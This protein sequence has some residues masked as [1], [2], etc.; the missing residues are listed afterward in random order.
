MYSQGHEFVKW[1]ACICWIV[2]MTHVCRLQLQ[3]IDIFFDIIDYEFESKRS[4]QKE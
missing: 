2:E 1:H 4:I 3:F